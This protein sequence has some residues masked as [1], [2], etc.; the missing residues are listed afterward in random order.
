MKNVF[1][2]LSILVIS[3]TLALAADKPAAPAADKPVTPAAMAAPAA[4]API[5]SAPAAGAPVA[6]QA[7]K[8]ETGK[9]KSVS[10]ADVVKGTKSEI[11]VVNDAG[12]SM[13]V[14]VKATTT[15]YDADSKAITLDKITMD[16]KVNVVYTVTGEGVNE[17]KSVKIVK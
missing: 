12:Q 10:M 13:T 8:T 1:Y 9:V 7:E 2:I 3:S 6:V 5:A 15:L 14:L 17:A 4:S 16:S 11:T